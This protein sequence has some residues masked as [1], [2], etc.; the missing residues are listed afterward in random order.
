MRPKFSDLKYNGGAAC[1]AIENNEWLTPEKI[2][3]KTNYTPLAL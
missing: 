2:A 3:V 1:G